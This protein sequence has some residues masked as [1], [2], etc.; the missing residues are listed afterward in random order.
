MFNENYYVMAE[1]YFKCSIFIRNIFIRKKK[2]RPKGRDFSNDWL[3]NNMWNT[4]FIQKYIVHQ[5]TFS[6]EN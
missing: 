6:N 2:S 4:F 1:Y 5:A 3:I